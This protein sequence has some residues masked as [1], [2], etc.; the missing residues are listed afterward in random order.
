MLLTRHLQRKLKCLKEKL[1]RLRE[2]F[3]KIMNVRCYIN[4]FGRPVTRL[5]FFVHIP[6]ASLC[7]WQNHK[8]LWVLT[9]IASHACQNYC[10]HKDRHLRQPHPLT[11]HVLHLMSM[12]IQKFFPPVFATCPH[13]CPDH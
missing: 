3:M 4:L 11:H 9:T 2:F 13:V 1:F 6:Q 12:S 7:S 8:S 10:K 5:S